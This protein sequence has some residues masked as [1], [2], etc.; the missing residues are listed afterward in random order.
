M[1]EFELKI[2]LVMKV[3]KENEKEL[4]KNTKNIDCRYQ[5]DNFD[6]DEEELFEEKNI[7][8][9]NEPGKDFENFVN[10]IKNKFII[11][12]STINESKDKLNK[13]G[14]NDLINIK[15]NINIYFDNKYNN[16]NLFSDQSHP[17]IINQF[18]GYSDFIKNQDMK[19][20]SKDQINKALIDINLSLKQENKIIIK[21]DNLNINISHFLKEFTD[22]SFS[23]IIYNMKMILK[24]S[25]I[26]LDV[27]RFNEQY[28]FEYGR[29]I[30]NTGSIIYNDFIT[31]YLKS[32]NKKIK[33]SL[34]KKYY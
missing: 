4:N 17:S 3:N 2:N 27:N 32:K 8:I 33:D 25:Q 7:L 20:N 9:N 30:F 19:S 1:N 31:P 21:E 16:S 15:E 23:D 34:Y 24:E 6:N 26:T 12:L 29:I 5:I 14:L 18:S 10:T 13:S 28:I 11:N 22:V